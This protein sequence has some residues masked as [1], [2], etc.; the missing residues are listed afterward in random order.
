MSG[1]L[2]FLDVKDVLSVVVENGIDPDDPRVMTRTNEAILAILCEIIP[3]N[4]M[5]TADVVADDTIV[6]LPKEMEAAY[7]V[8]VLDNAMVRGQTDVTQGFYNIVNQFVYV[9]PNMAM[10]NPMVDQ[11]LVPDGSDPSILRRQYDFPG[12]TPGATVRV[13]G[14]KRYVPITLGTDYLIVQNPL[15][16]KDMINSIEAREN[17]ND[18]QGAEAYHKA[19][20]DRLQAEVKKHM[21]DPIN[22][23]FR[24]SAYEDDMANFVQDTMGWTR[25]RIALE[26]PGA[27]M[28]GKR[29]L[30]RM[31]EMAEMRLMEKGTWRGTIQQYTASVVGGYIYFPREV[32]SVL[33]VDVCGQPIDIRSEF[34][35]YAENGPGM[36]GCGM[37]IDQGEDYFPGTKDLR[38]LYKLKGGTTAETISAICKLKWI[39]KQPSDRMTIQNHESLRLMVAAIVA[40]K[41]ED[42]QNAAMNQAAAVQVLNDELNDYL[43]GI[44]HAPQI[45]TYG[46]TMGSIGGM[47]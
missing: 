44:K 20:I 19:C 10:D 31:L 45:E 40:E 6:L 25:A 47:L 37:L 13:T 12:L 34:F 15:A 43:R 3:V 39:A 14:P 26:V 38:R 41:Q 18:P 4:S 24:K 7:E 22:S 29:Q 11:G 35:E 30:T 1:G 46:F 2:R 42:W 5:L 21:L 17:R 23:M 9:D 36:C 16:L 28:Q 27:M 8:H 33:A 32:L